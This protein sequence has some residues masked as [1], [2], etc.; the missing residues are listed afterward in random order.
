MDP[1]QEA[2]V[3]GFFAVG[4]IAMTSVLTGREKLMDEK[5]IRR[6]KRI[7]CKSFEKQRY[8]DYWRGGG[9][10]V[11]FFL[12]VIMSCNEKR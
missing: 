4:D 3:P 9:M 12:R 7:G 5:S 10:P 11:L 6:D 8:I 1:K 2:S